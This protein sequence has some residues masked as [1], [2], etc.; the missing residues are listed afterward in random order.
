MMFIIVYLH[1]LIIIISLD[2][3]ECPRVTKRSAFRN[4]KDAQDMIENV[5]KKFKETCEKE[6]DIDLRMDSRSEEET[7]YNEM[8]TGNFYNNY[9]GITSLLISKT[10]F[11]FKIHFKIY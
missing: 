10:L 2:N 11:F 3:L 7:F 6:L 8:M 5:A 1:I 4:P 9:I